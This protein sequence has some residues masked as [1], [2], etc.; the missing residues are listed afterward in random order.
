MAPDFLPEREGCNCHE[1]RWERMWE[2]KVWA[3]EVRSFILHIF[4]LTCL[5][6]IQVKEASQQHDIYVGVLSKVWAED[7]I[8]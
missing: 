2:E 7:I 5:L 3:E 1:L 6:V 4:L 8:L